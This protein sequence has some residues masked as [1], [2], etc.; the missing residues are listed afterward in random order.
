METRR[1]YAV[2]VKVTLSKVHGGFDSLD[3]HIQQRTRCIWVWSERWAQNMRCCV[4][5]TF[6]RV[7]GTI[8]ANCSCQGLAEDASATLT[9][10][11]HRF[12]GATTHH[13]H[14]IQ[15][16]IDLS[17]QNFDRF[18]LITSCLKNNEPAF[19]KGNLNKV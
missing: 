9:R 14:Y 10:S 7:V 11:I 8:C 4:F 19:C 13:M 16:T 18:M 2:D 15:W 5:P 12:C 6:V 3:Q 17:M 1:D